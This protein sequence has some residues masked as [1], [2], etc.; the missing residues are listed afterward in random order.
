MKVLT[1][2]LGILLI[3]GGIYC[4]FTPVAT[5]SAL[6][7]VIGVSM[8]VEGIGG[9]ITWGSAHR[10]GLANGW[11]LA[12]AILSL[13]LGVFLLGSYVLQFSLD[14]FIAFIIAFWFVEN[15]IVHIVAAIVARRE[16]GSEGASGWIIHL[17]LGILIVISGVLCI[18][19]PLSVMAGVRP[20]LGVSI[21]FVGAGLIAN[22]SE[23]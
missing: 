10:A 4:M 21:V 15:G 3:V 13:V 8:V 23:M 16:L 9:I 5:F 18:F 7:V 12:G 14:L 6:S 17:I 1:I 19:N 11:T 22:S 2:I 20:M